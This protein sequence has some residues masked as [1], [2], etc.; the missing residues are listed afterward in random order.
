MTSGNLS[1][2]WAIM[3]IKVSTDLSRTVINELG[4]SGP[5]TRYA[6]FDTGG[7]Y[8]TS[9]GKFSKQLILKAFPHKEA[10]LWNLDV[11][12]E[13]SLERDNLKDMDR[14]DFLCDCHKALMAKD[15]KKAVELAERADYSL[16]ACA[17]KH[18]WPQ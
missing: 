4:K 8:V 14:V 11:A 9:I 17:I 18:H 16:M 7:M 12:I 13:V 1:W 10:V 5:Y 6:N 15:I 2:A 3:D